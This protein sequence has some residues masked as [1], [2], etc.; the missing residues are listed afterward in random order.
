MLYYVI[1]PLAWLVWKI[2]FRTEYRGMD[3][4]QKVLSDGKGYII[5]PNHVSALDPV[6]I[7][8]S[9]WYFYTHKM[10]VFAKKELYE[11]NA[12]VSWFINQMGAVAVK[13]GRDDLETLNHTIEEVK[14]GRGLLLF[15]EGT[16]SRTGALLPPKGGAFMVADQANVAMVP[17]RILYDT[18]TGQMKLFCRV[19]I[20]YG[21]PIPAE[22]LSLGGKKDM[23]RLRE[24]RKL[25]TAA[26]EKL[27]DENAFP[28]RSLPAP[29]PK[30][31]AV[32]VS[33][34]EQKEN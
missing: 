10:R 31:K 1:V 15:P 16:R 14:G 12:L 20:C 32:P 5:A 23:R 3:N 34:A 30:K 28:G 8:V 29:E 26:W 17:C 27:W 6:F 24:N 9:T 33:E 4:L 21:E 13:T 11:V 18:P 22:V 7:V 2:I 19:R 25:L